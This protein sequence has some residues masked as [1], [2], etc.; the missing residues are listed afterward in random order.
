MLFQWS[1]V[2]CHLVKLA[3]WHMDIDSRPRG[4]PEDRDIATLPGTLAQ[5]KRTY[6]QVILLKLGH[7]E[8]ALVLVF[9][10]GLL[11]ALIEGV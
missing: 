6:Q 11:D 10:D 3:P 7:L 4:P 5:D 2:W 1:C 8:L 9:L